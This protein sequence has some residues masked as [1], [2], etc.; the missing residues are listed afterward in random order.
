MPGP[1]DA[2]DLVV[3]VAVVPG[4]RRQSSSTRQPASAPASASRATR[5]S[6]TTGTAACLKASTG[7]TLRLTKRTSGL[8]KMLWEAVAKSAQRVPTPTTTS[9]SRAMALAPSV[10]VTPIA[11]RAEGW[12]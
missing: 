3:P 2:L 4:R 10:P 9:A 12:S 1:V 8:V 7:A 11:P 6:A 5:A